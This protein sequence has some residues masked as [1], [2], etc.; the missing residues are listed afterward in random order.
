MKRIHYLILG[1]LVSLCLAAVS[2][3]LPPT[4]IAPGS[5]ISVTTNGV[6]SFTLVSSGR[7]HRT[8][9]VDSTQ[10]VST[11]GVYTDLQ[12]NLLPTGTL[13]N[14]GDALT[15]TYAGRFTNDGVGEY[16]FLLWVNTNCILTIPNQP[17][18]SSAEDAW[19]ISGSITRVSTTTM[20]C[21]AVLEEQRYP[22]GQRISLSV[23]NAFGADVSTEFPIYL[24][25][26]GDSSPVTKQVFR[27][28]YEPAP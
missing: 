9:I 15:F 3:T 25:G 12:S 5:G 17:F 28:N 1:L 24:Q 26:Y 27:L 4:R 11:A 2:P 16:G 13:T 18:A 21:V 20:K 22:D 8:L 10:T 19:R 23:S 6:N 14:N 7:F